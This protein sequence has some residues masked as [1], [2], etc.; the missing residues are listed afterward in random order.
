MQ[1]KLFEV[2]KKYCDNCICIENIKELDIETVVKF[3][4]IGIMAGA[5]TPQKSIEDVINKLKTYE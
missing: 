1:K 4:K 2:S 3:K 5:S